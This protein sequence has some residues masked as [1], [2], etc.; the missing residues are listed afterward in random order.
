MY[1]ALTLGLVAES[2]KVLYHHPVYNLPV[3]AHQPWTHAATPKKAV[4]TYAKNAKKENVPFSSRM[5]QVDHREVAKLWDDFDLNTDGLIGFHDM[6][7]ASTYPIIEDIES[8]KGIM[9]PEIIR[10]AI[11][12]MDDGENPL[13]TKSL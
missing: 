10:R 1:L 6:R 13:F 11:V 3:Y 2:A 12:E 7:V 9:M 8:R 4:T 5:C